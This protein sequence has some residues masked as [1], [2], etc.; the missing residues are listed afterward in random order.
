[1]LVKLKYFGQDIVVLHEYDIRNQ[2]HPFE[3][4]QSV[5]IRGRFMEELNTLIEDA[6][7]KIV[8]T[9]INKQLLAETYTGS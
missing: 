6:E 1:M 7:L 9:V 5:E 3:F 2:R 4:L 8:A